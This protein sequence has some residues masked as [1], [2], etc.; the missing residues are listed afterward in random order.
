METY[1]A[2]Y[3]AKA[4]KAVE[5]R[6]GHKMFFKKFEVTG[7]ENLNKSP[8]DRQRLYIS[9]HQSHADYLLAWLQFHRQQAQMPMIAAGTN[10]DLKPLQWMGID[11]GKLGAFWIDRNGIKGKERGATR[12]IKSKIP[13]LIKDGHDIL[14]FPEGGRSYDGSI[15]TDYK[16]GALKRVLKTGRDLDIV[17][18]AF[19]YNSRIEHGYFRLLKATKKLRVDPKEIRE[20][21]SAFLRAAKKL[22]NA[23]NNGL[24]LGL[25]TIAFASR[26]LSMTSGNAYMNV[27]KPQALETITKTAND[28]DGEILAVENHSKEEIK[29]LYKEISK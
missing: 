29:R 19:N 17:Y 21:S 2:E 12:Q 28:L 8:N 23:V 13:R 6:R 27:G 26:Y 9:N 5:Q 7:E 16:T 10:L 4:L 11:F 25:D 15:F 14:I 18:I 20:E 3:A 24:Y 22:R 1:D